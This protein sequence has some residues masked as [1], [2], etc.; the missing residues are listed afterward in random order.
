MLPFH[1]SLQIK[2]HDEDKL[3]VQRPVGEQF[4][5]PP[6]KLHKKERDF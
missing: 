5:G 6:A 1:T 2:T 3:Y 4:R